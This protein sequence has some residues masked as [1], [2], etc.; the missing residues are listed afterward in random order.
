MMWEWLLIGATGL[1]VAW[2]IWQM[3]KKKDLK[4]ELSRNN[5]GAGG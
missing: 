5:E 1:F 3:L 2:D 4:K